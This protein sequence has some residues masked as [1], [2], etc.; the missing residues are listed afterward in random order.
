[1]QITTVA[2]IDDHPVMR[3]GVSAALERRK[4]YSLVASGS[5]AADIQAI[6]VEHHPDILIVDLGMPGDA[7][8]AIARAKGLAPSTKILVFTASTDVEDALHAFDAGAVGYALKRNA[9]DQLDDAMETVLRGDIYITS[10]MSAD[11]M[12]ALK[13]KSAKAQSDHMYGLSSRECE[14]VSSLMRGQKNIEIASIMKLSEKT[15]KNYMTA[16]MRKFN[17][18]NR[19]ELMLSLQKLSKKKP[20][21]S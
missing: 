7:F 2:F 12:R 15:I 5:S 6:L 19:L 20:E 9:I 8:E 16:L 4:R 1:M 18:K 10:S 11:V 14:V 13:E 21:R 3:E 17:V